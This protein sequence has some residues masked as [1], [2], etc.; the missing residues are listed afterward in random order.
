MVPDL[1]NER[2]LRT[3]RHQQHGHGCEP[4]LHIAQMQLHTHAKRLAI[5]ALL[6]R[7]TK[8]NVGQPVVVPHHAYGSTLEV[9]DFDGLA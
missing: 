3:R 8:F 1:L 9:M 5:D 6:G 2:I 4:A 7:M